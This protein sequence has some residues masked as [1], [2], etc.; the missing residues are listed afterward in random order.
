MGKDTRIIRRTMVALVTI[1][2]ILSV[3]LCIHSVTGHGL[4]GCSQGSHCNQVLGSRWSFLLGTVPVSALA[5]GTYLVLLACLKLM[6]RPDTE[7]ETRE[8]LCR[9]MLF[10]C[11]AIIGCAVWFIYLQQHIIRAFCPYCMTAHILGIII[12]VL[13]I[14][15]CIPKKNGKALLHIIIGIVAAALLA[16]L[17]LLTTPRTL[18]ERGF[19]EEELSLPDPA[20]MPLIGPADATHKITLMFDWQCSH[21]RKLHLML[22]ETVEALNDSVAFVCCPVSLS[23]ECNPYLPAGPDSFQGSCTLLRIGMAI[24]NTDRQ[25]YRN[26]E[27]WFFDADPHTGWYPPAIEQA[28]QKAAALIGSQ[29]LQSAMKSESIDYYISDILEV[30]GRTSVGGLA[31]IPRLIYHRQS[32]IP[33][34][35]TPADLAGLIR[36]LIE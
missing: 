3:I 33:D 16:V 35:D 26:Y 7:P 30:F 2:L 19:I 31:A 18:S 4:I 28:E 1:V 11:G 9:I 17:Q 25:A 15:F 12:S 34:A 36:S 22:P 24:W 10:L 8:L 29:T 27:E 6:D 32:M 23:N 21:C 14:A 5:T 20:E 13:Y